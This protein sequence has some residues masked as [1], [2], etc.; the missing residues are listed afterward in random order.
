MDTI[1]VNILFEKNTFEDIELIKNNLRDNADK[2]KD[3]LRQ[4]IG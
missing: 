2:K 4:I 1:N 3:E